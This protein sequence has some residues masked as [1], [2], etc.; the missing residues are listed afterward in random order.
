MFELIHSGVKISSIL[1]LNFHL[2]Y[3]VM[4][5]IMAFSYKHYALFLFVPIPIF[6]TPCSLPTLA[7]SLPFP[8]WFTYSDF[9]NHMYSIMLSSNPLKIA[10]FCGFYILL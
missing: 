7:G 10:S 3:T 2:A 9:F 8:S 5:V 4:G 1:K 6:P